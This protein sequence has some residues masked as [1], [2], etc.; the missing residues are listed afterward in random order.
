M[1]SANSILETLRL[2]SRNA[3]VRLDD[4]DR[5]CWPELFRLLALA[6][7]LPRLA[8]NRSLQGLDADAWPQLKEVT[9]DLAHL[10]TLVDR[11]TVPEGVRTAPI[12]STDDLAGATAELEA[13]HCVTV[14]CLFDDG[15]RR[16]LDEQ[17]ES[18]CQT[19]MGTWGQLD[20][21]EAEDLFALFDDALASDRFHQ[22]TGYDSSRDTY[23][24][25]LSLQ[26]LDATGIGWHRDLYWPKEWVGED[27]FAVL[28]GLGD[29]APAKG[30][31]F[32]HY[33]PWRDE[34]YASYRKRHQATILWNSRDDEGRLL[35]AVSGY[36][37]A[38][39]S[40]HLIILQCLRRG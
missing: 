16:R 6:A 33:V 23:T 10:H 34:L 29:D 36:H 38:D 17:I 1:P 22:L 40:R 25:T 28:Y 37:T 12:Y 39:T 24:L 19:K 3:E 15:G 7:D 32:L 5:S 13:S 2:S 14:D 21:A 18:L 9:A 11:P 4:F 31:A 27:V 26:N 8:T 30:G 35:H 20:R